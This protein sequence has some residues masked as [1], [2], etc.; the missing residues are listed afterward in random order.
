MHPIITQGMGF[1]ALTLEWGSFQCKRSRNLFFVQLLANVTYLL[2]FLLLG[3]YSACV[4]LTISCLRNLVLMSRKPWAQWKG[5]PWVLVAANF[6][7]MAFTWEGWISLLPFFGVT[8][9]TLSGWTRNGKKVRLATLFVSAP[10]WL[11]Y[12]VF[13]GSLSGILCQS[14]TIG[15]VLIS[16]LRFGWKALDVVEAPDPRE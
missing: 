6:A 2:H 14:L 11:I 10:S 8:S 1:L 7:A 15:S 12:D 16:V 9:L 3:G 13:S 4:S 5:W